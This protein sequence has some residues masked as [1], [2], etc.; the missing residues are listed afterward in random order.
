MKEFT[1]IEIAKLFR[2]VAAVYSITNEK[3]YKFQIIAY[4]KAAEVVEKLSAELSTLFK[5]QS[6]DK[7][8]GIG[9]TMQERLTELFTTGQVK[10]YE[11]IMKDVSPAVFPL[12]DI[13]SFGPK[14]AFRLV[15][16]FKLTDPATIIEI[17]RAH[18]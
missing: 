15:T 9:A 7:I 3:K 1:N 11:N 5:Q 8:P 13:P 16:H 2:Q 12:L 14:K 6:L 18:V 4:Q 17:G 10:H